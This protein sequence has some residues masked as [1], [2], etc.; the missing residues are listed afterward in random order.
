M[1]KQD[2][3]DKVIQCAINAQELTKTEF[4]MKCENRYI[5]IDIVA[6][7]SFI[8]L[9]KEEFGNVDINVDVK[10]CSA[11]SCQV[12]YASLFFAMSEVLGQMEDGLNWAY[13]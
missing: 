11:I 8:Y 9:L 12:W 2:F 5:E 10:I 4:E 7:S 3:R 6:L 1:T 13:K